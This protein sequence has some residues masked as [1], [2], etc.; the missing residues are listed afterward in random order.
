M[1]QLLLFLLLLTGCQSDPPDKTSHFYGTAMTM[2]Y[3]IIVGSH[4]SQKEKKRVQQTLDETF[5][6]V[7]QI[8][9]RFNPNS[10]VSHLNTMPKNKTALLSKELKELLI[11]TDEAVSM[12]LGK[13]DPTIHN[14][15]LVWK[16]YLEAGQIPP[17]DEIEEAS[18]A[19]GWKQIQIV[20][21]EF[22]KGS[23]LL[24]LDLGGIAKGHCIDL[25]VANLQNLGFQDLFVEWGGEIRAAG[26]HPEERP[27]T[28]MISRLDDINPENA[29]EILPLSD[30]A[31]ATSGDYLQYW[32]AEGETY[33]HVINPETRSPL[34]AH[35]GSIASVTVK[36]PTCA[37]ADALATAAMVFD[38]VLEAKTWAEKLRQQKPELAFWFISREL[39]SELSD[40]SQ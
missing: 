3:H 22:K 33:C 26:K 36:A 35:P 34:K 39:S 23:D 5:T 21:K 27:W 7:D 12:T 38:S 16:K 30:E 11:M 32:E 13:F 9:N 31:V 8:F 24:K 6:R 17:K 20:G 19:V 40:P 4:L 14:L 37:M 15:Q 25:I 10:E 18:K 28:I 1:K 2:N 29:V